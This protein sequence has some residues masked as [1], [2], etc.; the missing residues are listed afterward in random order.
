M[1]QAQEKR[2]TIIC[3]TGPGGCGKSLVARHLFREHGFE[4]LSF[5]SPLKDGCRAMFGLS[6]EQV[7]E[8]EYKGAK[9]RFWNTTPRQMLQIV[10][11]ELM[12]NEL[13]KHLP[14]MKDVWIRQMIRRIHRKP[15]GAR[16]VIDDLRFPDEF[17]AMKELGAQVFRIVGRGQPVNNHSSETALAAQQLDGEIDNS[18]DVYALFEKVDALVP[19]NDAQAEPEERQY[20]R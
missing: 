20:A 18:G 11:T 14:G 9:D 12:R 10:G 16:I 3:V 7:D 6:M 4:R 8:P 5:A 1:A 13:P 19:K 15:A 2:Y 17:K